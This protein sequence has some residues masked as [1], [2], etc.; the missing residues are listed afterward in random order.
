MV[1][2]GIKFGAY[3]TPKPLR[4]LV[5]PHLLLGM[6]IR[7]PNKNYGRRPIEGLSE[8]ETVVIKLSALG[9]T[10]GQ[11]AT[12][13]YRSVNTIKSHAKSAMRKLGASTRAHAVYL[14]LKQQILF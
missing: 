4:L 6:I 2:G 11:I 14:A 10:D 9:M 1:Y 8:H 5:V 12:L 13:R 3:P 7:L